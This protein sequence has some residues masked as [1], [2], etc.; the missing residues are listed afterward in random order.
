MAKVLPSDQRE[1]IDRLKKMRKDLGYSQE[2]F[3]EILEINITTYKKIERYNRRISLNNY[4]MMR[5]KLNLS[6]DYIL[7]GG[8][9]T[10]LG[11]WYGE[12]NFPEEDT[13]VRLLRVYRFLSVNWPEKWQTDDGTI[14]RLD[15]M[16]RILTEEE[17]REA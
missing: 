2:E 16:I 17:H 11:A 4:K 10:Q 14:E 1:E 15:E 9:G 5:K 6:V 3:A 13:R 8:D 7:S 12:I